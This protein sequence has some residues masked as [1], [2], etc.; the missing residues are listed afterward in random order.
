MEFKENLKQLRKKNGLTQFELSQL[1]NVEPSTVG[2]WEQTGSIPNQNTLFKLCEILGCTTDYLL[3]RETSQSPT[4]S[5]MLIARGGKQNTF[6]LNEERLNYLE[7]LHKSNS[8]VEF[9]QLAPTIQIPVFGEIPAGKPIEA[10]EDILEYIDI[11]ADWT[12]G[13]HQYFGLHVKGNSML[14]DFKNGDTIILKKQSTCDNGQFC[15]VS[16]NGTEV[17]FKKVRRQENGITLQPLNPEYDPI[18]FTNK[19][20]KEE[21]VT[22]LGVV[23]EARRKF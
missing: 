13:G 4:A 17:T 1:A 16:V 10:C 8:N 23:V 20:I 11:P 19:Q 9:I 6:A 12:K 7:E 2:K 21:P 18:F 3:G 15:A 5:G 14:P 22:I